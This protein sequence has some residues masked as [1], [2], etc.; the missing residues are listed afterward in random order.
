[1]RFRHF[2]LAAGAAAAFALAP[3]QVA[4]GQQSSAPAAK[5]AP[6]APFSSDR[7]SV[8]VQGEGPDVI[9]I[10]GL[11][12][13]REIWKGTVAAVPGYRY[14]LVQV[15]G[16]AGTKAGANASGP[17]V[18]PVAHEIARYIQHQ[19]LQKPALIGHS[20]GGIISMMIAARQ[21]HL[22]GKLMVVDMLPQPAGLFGGSASG[23]GSL[24]D[25]L[26][27]TPNGKR[28][29]GALVGTFGSEAARQSD[30]DVVAQASHDL[31]RT[32]L[33][34]ELPKIAAPMTV[35]FAS[36][37]AASPD[38]A[39]IVQDYRSAYSGAPKAKLRPIP[40]S[41]HMIMFH[42]PARFRAEVKD[43]LKS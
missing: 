43:F 25:R 5:A 32:N 12:S 29:I 14:H 35:L 26:A 22:V 15:N 28:L 10:P 24:A 20:M 4:G 42:Q 33:T 2:I 41:G 39:R 36:P 19:K 11:T 27:A 7:I 8:V 18:E 34:P 16:F 3:A 1:M 30:P 40:E 21:P 17:V 38:H 31:A 37:A 9:L 13:P 23:L 6:A